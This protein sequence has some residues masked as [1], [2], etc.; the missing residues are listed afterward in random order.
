MQSV[1]LTVS[2]G[3]AF[4]FANGN[5]RT[6][7]VFAGV[8]SIMAGLHRRERQV[9]SVDLEVV[10]VFQS[11]HGDANRPGTKL[12]LNGIVVEVEERESRVG[13]QADHRRPE[14]HF[15]A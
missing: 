7:A 10:I 5:D 15:G 6:A 4:A 12:D 2:G 14:L 11:A 1:G 8:N 3:L 9:R 13:R